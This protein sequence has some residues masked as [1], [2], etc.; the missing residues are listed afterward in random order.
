M[1]TAG[2]ELDLGRGALTDRAVE[3]EAEPEAVEEPAV[4]A[5]VAEEAAEEG[6]DADAEA[7]E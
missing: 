3:A 5:E 2:E 6:T 1:G 4:E 7:A